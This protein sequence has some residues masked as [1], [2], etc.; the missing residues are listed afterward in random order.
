[1][2]NFY[3]KIEGY[4]LGELEGEVLADF[5]NALKTDT[6]LAQSVA[7]HRAMMQRLEALRL[8][9]KVVSALEFEPKKPFLLGKKRLPGLLALLIVLLAAAFYFFGK[10]AAKPSI[11]SENLPQD[12]LV[13]PAV[14]PPAEVPVPI[15]EKPKEPSVEKPQLIAV[16]RAF[17]EP[18]AQTFVR[19][20]AQQAGDPAPKTS[21]EKA[22]ESFTDQKFRL[23]ANLLGDENLVVQ[24]E[25]ARYIRAHARFM[26]GQFAGAASDFDALINSFQF[27]YEARWNFLL[28][29]IA[30]G[31]TKKAK[32]LLA[33]IVAEDD[34]PFRSK[35]LELSKRL[36]AF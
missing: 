5:E 4:I 20:A 31:K 26:I 12:T 23:A 11:K 33:E 30:L 14:R 32:A 36:A 3:E 8:R 27:K 7:R 29:Q 13:T 25:E 15:A 9:K 10:P 16:A 18:P 6:E 34:F 24:D 28:C 19:D 22:A 35:A 21:L 2:E 1:M 17:H